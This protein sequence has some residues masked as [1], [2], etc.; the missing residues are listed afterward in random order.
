MRVR[1]VSRQSEEKEGT[2]KREINE[3]VGSEQLK[4]MYGVQYGVPL[5]SSHS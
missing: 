1:E 3:R 5:M 4:G 2:K